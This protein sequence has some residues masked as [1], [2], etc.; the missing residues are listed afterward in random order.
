M[1]RSHGRARKALSANA[2]QKG[3]EM[4]QQK[5]CRTHCTMDAQK[6]R[7]C[8][9]H[10]REKHG[11]T[12][13]E[14]RRLGTHWRKGRNYEET[15]VAP[16]GRGYNLGAV[17]AGWMMRNLNISHEDVASALNMNTEDVVERRVTLLQKM[18]EG[19][20][21]SSEYIINLISGLL[22]DREE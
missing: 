3:M 2:I 11:I 9:R 14:A 16:D 19:Y 20:S 13:G 8:S 6:D 18:F 10:F 5:C 15:A 4:G 7:L 17:S 22:R 1:D 21:P 12:V